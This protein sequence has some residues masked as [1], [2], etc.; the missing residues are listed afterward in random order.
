MIFYSFLANR[1]AASN[2][3]RATVESAKQNAFYTFKISHLV[4]TP[5][6]NIHS[7]LHLRPL[8]CNHDGIMKSNT[9]YTLYS[10][11]CAC[12]RVAL[13]LLGNGY[14]RLL[15]VLLALFLRRNQSSCLVK[16][17]LKFDFFFFLRKLHINSSKLACNH[18]LLSMNFNHRLIVFRFRLSI[19]I[20]RVTQPEPSWCER[21]EKFKTILAARRLW[22][23]SF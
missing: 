12:V 21:T 10:T 3:L 11:L 23:F 2:F 18:N 14:L 8:R 9:F 13:F 22:N 19:Q 15:R 20:F 16:N 4:S 17:S 7:C 1:F 6:I 5:P